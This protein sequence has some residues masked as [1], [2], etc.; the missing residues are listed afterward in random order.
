[1]IINNPY[2]KQ[3]SDGGAAPTADGGA[4]KAAAAP[5]ADPIVIIDLTTMGIQ[6]QSRSTNSRTIRKRP[7][8]QYFKQG[9][10][11][12]MDGKKAFNS[13]TDCVVCKAQVK[14]LKAPHRS[15]HPSC[16][17]NQKTRGGRVSQAALEFS[18]IMAEN[19]KKNSVPVVFNIKP[20]AEALTVFFTPRVDI[21]VAEPPDIIDIMDDDIMDDMDL[22]INPVINPPAE[23]RQDLRGLVRGAMSDNEFVEFLQDLLVETGIHPPDK[24]NLHGVVTEAMSNKAFL[25]L[26]SDVK[27]SAPLPMVA[28]ARHVAIDLVPNKSLGSLV[29][30]HTMTLTVP[31]H[32]VVGQQ[33]DPHYH[34]I[35]GQQL[36]LVQWETHFPGLILQ[37]PCYGCVGTLKEDR[38]NFSK[39]KK[40]FP[41]FRAHG[42]P[43]WCIVMSYTCKA[44]KTRFEGNDGQ[45]LISLPE[46]VRNAYPVYPKYAGKGA[47]FHIDRN[48][49][50][51][52]D[53]L[54]P[55]YGNGDML[56]RLMFTKINKEYLKQ[57]TEYLSFWKGFQFVA[58][59]AEDIVT[60][61]LYPKKD[62]EFITVYPPTGE[63]IRELFDMA[64]LSNRTSYG[65]S[66]QD[67]CTREIQSVGTNSMFAQ[68]HTFQVVKN[69]QKK[70]GAFAVWDCAT[71]TGEIASACLV[72]STKVKE[73]AHAAESLA[74]R[75]NFNPVVMFS[76]TW[77]HKDGFW[78]LLFGPAFDGRLGL[79]HYQQRIIKTLR[80][81]HHDYH[82][83]VKDLCECVYE[84]E[85]GT[86]ASLLEALG[87]GKM[88]RNSDKLSRK[89]VMD[90]QMSP[91][92]KRK[93]ARFLMK[94][95]W[96][97]EV[98]SQKLEEWFCSY[99]V[100]SSDPN[101]RPG[102]GRPDPL[103]G[104]KLFTIDTKVAVVE[105]QRN[106]RQIQDALPL[107]EMYRKIP[108]TPCTKH[109]LPEYVSL[110]CESKLEGFHDPLSNFANS[111]MAAS[112]CD[113]L[114]LS[115]TAGFNV[116]IRHRLEMAEMAANEPASSRPNIPSFWSN[117]PSFT[118]H[119]ELAYANDL[120]VAAIYPVVPFPS[121]RPLPPDNGERFFSQYLIEETQRQESIPENPL[122]DRCHCPKCGGNSE[123]LNHHEWPAME[124]EKPQ[125][126]RQ[127][128]VEVPMAPQRFVRPRLLP[129]PLQQNPMPMMA[130]IEPM[131]PM[132]QW[133]VPQ[134]QP[135][136]GI[137][138]T[139]RPKAQQQVCCEPFLQWASRT[140]RNGRPPHSK[141][142]PCAT[143]RKKN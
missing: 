131:P 43:S 24:P 129:P 36:L 119:C 3:Q 95:I 20:T 72:K 58:S 80:Q 47:T 31:V 55:T 37:C 22:V 65:I 121:A 116:K 134:I 60:P 71:E 32:R 61:P 35:E 101:E 62:G 104:K 132:F 46:Y 76:D 81:G 57:F 103:T 138:Q 118:N 128:Q 92:F 42:P 12:T 77:P 9:Q 110:R 88:G 40:L 68:D 130:R 48:C 96:P 137:T 82:R 84:W 8:Y 93:Y 1:M 98:I 141:D 7:E 41:L 70:L 52:V 64:S 90:M 78:K 143:T 38:T 100:E 39:N 50:D 123:E 111:G 142:C 124:I 86:Y 16:E 87:Q 105:G 23:T 10:Q 33:L 125:E 69:Y 66:D 29:P 99:K 107:A 112:L 53:Y 34:S 44:C 83:A 79:F 18:R 120:A 15:H 56:A 73:V 113:T 85:P 17:Q 14:N 89:D 11:K 49:A 135:N 67:R 13:A 45:L 133:A 6:S 117:N 115:G 25:D 59:K 109:G 114:N 51:L 136:W 127:L 126:S 140:N 74:R 97:A 63:S 94:R 5:T 4:A 2:S 19:K 139:Q 54:M 102:R 106:A 91:T 30:P 21:E 75:P 28:L 27:K 122:N 108:A 26:Y